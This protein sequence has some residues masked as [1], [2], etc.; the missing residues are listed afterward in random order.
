[1]VIVANVCPI[2]ITYLNS[3]VMPDEAQSESEEEED[4]AEDDGSDGESAES[5]GVGDDDEA[6]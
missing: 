6:E 1:V 2:Q 4:E 5:S 3:V